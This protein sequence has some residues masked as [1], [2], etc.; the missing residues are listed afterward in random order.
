MAGAVI[1]GCA[2]GTEETASGTTGAGATTGTTGQPSRVVPNVT[3]P[4]TQA[5]VKVMFLTGQGRRVPGSQYARMNNIR[6]KNGELDQI[7]SDI[8]GS[9]DG[10]N[11]K[12]DGFTTNTFTFNEPINETTRSYVSLSMF[13][14]TVREE[15]FAGDLNLVYPGPPIMLPDLPVNVTLRPGRT[16]A[17]QVYFND[18]SL[19]YDP[20]LNEVVFDQ[21]AWNQDNLVNGETSIPA[22]Y[23]D[24]IAFNIG[25]VATRP[26]MQAGGT[27]DRVL[28]T[29]DS[30]GLARGSAVN[31][32]FDLY[33]PQFVESGS[34][35]LPDL[36]SGNPGGQP[37]PGAYTVLEP[38][39][40]PFAPPGAPPLPALQGTWYEFNDV[41]SNAGG[42]TMVIIPSTSGDHQVA[43]VR[44]NAGGTITA[45]WV[46]RA[47]L[48]GNSGTFTVWSV[49]QI[50]D[51]TENN[52]VSG[53]FSN[54]TS[55]GG[56]VVDGDFAVTG[57]PSGFPFTTSGVFVVYN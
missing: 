36:L 34:L 35:T 49:D 40:T 53:T 57:T 32:S 22:S 12:L 38:D 4:S 16:S 45:M 55:V 48:S 43:L 24:A 26:A 33:S 56:K 30:I 42:D 13:V 29:G 27:A 46:G 21:D 1:V 2:G 7:P 11:L 15:N 5:A 20:V 3:L 14:E 17:L 28:L 39:T 52:A 19:F 8:N 41:V 54:L 44:R 6:L 25:S 51:N 37:L 47:T 31:G 50:D 10:V 9:L 18:G 23:S